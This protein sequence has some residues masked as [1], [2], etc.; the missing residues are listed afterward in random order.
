MPGKGKY[1]SGNRREETTSA[2]QQVVH[3]VQS[4]RVAQGK[5]ASGPLRLLLVPVFF[6][7][8][9]SQSLAAVSCVA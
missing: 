5:E 6:H 3:R 1:R 4:T 7:L 2:G 9:W 8:L